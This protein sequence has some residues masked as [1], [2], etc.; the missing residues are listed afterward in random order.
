MTHIPHDLVIGCVIDIMQ[1]NCQLGDTEAGPEM[2][3]ISA[4]LLNNKLPEF[5]TDPDQVQLTQLPEIFRG[6]LF[7]QAASY[8]LT[9]QKCRK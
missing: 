9:L 6:S 8:S 2:T 4:Y 5:I 1:G 3:G 7:Y